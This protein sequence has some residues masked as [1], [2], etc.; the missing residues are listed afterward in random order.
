MEY[1]PWFHAVDVLFVT[2]VI[3]MLS[4]MDVPIHPDTCIFKKRIVLTL[5]SVYT[6]LV[7]SKYQM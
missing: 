3:L 2:S 5:V 4:V 6:S 1:P 7:T